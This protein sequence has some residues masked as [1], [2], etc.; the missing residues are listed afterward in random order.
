MTVKTQTRTTVICD[1]CGRAHYSHEG[2]E[3]P[4]RLARVAA[5]ADGWRLRYVAA[6]PDAP[7]QQVDLCPTCKRTWRSDAEKEAD[8]LV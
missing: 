1:G 8:A 2:T 6:D 5:K 4:V 3:S 7:V